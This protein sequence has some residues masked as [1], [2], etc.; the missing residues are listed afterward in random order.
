MFKGLDQGYALLPPPA[1][2]GNVWKYFA[3]LSGKAELLA[4]GG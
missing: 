3:C 1:A 4:S 2:G